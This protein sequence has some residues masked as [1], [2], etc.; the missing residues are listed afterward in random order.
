MVDIMLIVGF[1]LCIVDDTNFELSHY[2]CNSCFVAGLYGK[3]VP[4]VDKVSHT[5]VRT[6]IDENFR[7]FVSIIML[8]QWYLRML[9]KLVVSCID[10]RDDGNSGSILFCISG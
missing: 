2:N 9:V 6:H 5:G 10:N 1:L 3:V 8:I 7:M 4:N